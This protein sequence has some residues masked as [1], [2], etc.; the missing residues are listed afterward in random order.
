MSDSNLI[1]R[2]VWCGHKNDYLTVTS[3]TNAIYCT[4]LHNVVECSLHFLVPSQRFKVWYFWIIDL[5]ICK[6]DRC[7]GKWKF[8]KPS[9]L[10][11]QLMDYLFSALT[12]SNYY[13]NNC[14]ESFIVILMISIGSRIKSGM[15]LCEAVIIIEYTC[16]ASCITLSGLIPQ[17]WKPYRMLALISFIGSL[18]SCFVCEGRGIIVILR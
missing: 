1:F 3:T 11:C 15:M 5:L 14:E 13:W 8:E 6:T 4:A 7:Q 10:I 9:Q 12:H 18:M 2:A 16:F 17:L